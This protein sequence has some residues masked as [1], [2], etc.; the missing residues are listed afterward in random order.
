MSDGNSTVGIQFTLPF[1]LSDV[2]GAGSAYLNTT[3]LSLIQ[4]TSRD[5]IWPQRQQIEWSLGMERRRRG[6]PIKFA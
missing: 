3:G 4:W 5:D 2:L 1:S 6:R